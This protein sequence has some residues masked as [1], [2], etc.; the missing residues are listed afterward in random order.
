MSGC[1]P[2]EGVERRDSLPTRSARPA[3]RPLHPWRAWF[4]HT[5]PAGERARPGKAMRRFIAGQELNPIERRCALTRVTNTGPSSVLSRSRRAIFSSAGAPICAGCASAVFNRQ[6]SAFA[7][8]YTRARRYRNMSY[9]L[10]ASRVSR[11]DGTAEP[12]GPGTYAVPA[13]PFLV[14]HSQRGD[15]IA[16]PPWPLS[17]GRLQGNRPPRRLPC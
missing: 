9:T 14:P 1:R 7:T 5:S 8:H 13:L 2:Q 16:F 6:A 3:R 17:Q 10:F 11:P 4:R 12:G 15:A